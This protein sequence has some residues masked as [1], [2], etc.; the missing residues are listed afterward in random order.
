MQ[1]EGLPNLLIVCG[2]HGMSEQGS[3]GG[4]S[5]SE[6]RVPLLLLST[7]NMTS[8]GKTGHPSCYCPRC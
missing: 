5:Y 2:D 1:G 6:T 3:H 4:A 7:H 8:T